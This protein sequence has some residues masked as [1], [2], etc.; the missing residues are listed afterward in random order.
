MESHG[1]EKVRTYRARASGSGGGAYLNA[2][3]EQV[4]KLQET[5][6]FLVARLTKL[7]NALGLTEE[8]PE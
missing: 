7:E 1:I 4:A 6:D 8:N 3:R 2:V 5:V